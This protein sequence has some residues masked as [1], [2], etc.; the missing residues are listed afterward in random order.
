MMIK[1]IRTAF[2]LFILCM[3]V[4]AGGVYQ[5]DAKTVSVSKA[6]K[7][8]PW[9][10]SYYVGYQNRY[11]K[12]Q[13]VDY[14]LMTH[15]AVG[16]VGV[17]AD[18]SLDP[19]FSLENGSTDGSGKKM[20]RDVATR[21]RQFGTKPLLWLGG[22]N[23]EDDLRAA[24][25][26]PTR[27]VFIKNILTLAD[28][29]GYVGVDI[30]WEPIR[31]KDREPLL[32]LVKDLRAA[33]SD[34]IITVPVNWIVS[35]YKYELSHEWY[36]ELARYADKLFIMTYSM[37][38]P[39]PGWSVWHSG[40][41]AGESDETPSSVRTSVATYLE[42]G[43]PKE[44]LGFGVGL[45]AECW[46]YPA[47]KPELSPGK[48]FSG[49]VESLTMRYMQKEFFDKKSLKWDSSAKT[50]YLS[51]KKAKGD[52]QCGFISFEDARS[53]REKSAFL[54]KQKLG[55]VIV[56]NLGTGYFP[57]EPMNKRFPLLKEV[58]RSVF[59]A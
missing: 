28:E 30:D 8:K 32:A 17:N 40:A 16:A 26:D 43:V 57:K 56:W 35:N 19:H 4:F 53:V 48:N 37:A 9:V 2:F 5:A 42:A 33:R 45:Y 31:E 3:T 51:F 41:L 29:L 34:F 52:E 6:K 11:L 50:P 22:P 39:W 13:D 27:A 7:E 14:S 55:G 46:P 38:G 10:M 58:Y 24:S 44:K 47:K 25:S 18:G 1:N 15:V 59:D 12:P 20:A 54:K 49:R 21:A 23:D 36:A